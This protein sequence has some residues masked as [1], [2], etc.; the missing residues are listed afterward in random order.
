MF[1]SNLL[2]EVLQ[3]LSLNEF[4]TIV[5]RGCF[6]VLTKKDDT[7]L[8]K[9]LGN[10]DSFSEEHANNMKVMS[11]F[12]SAK[13]LTV[14]ARCNRNRLSDNVVYSRFGIPIMSLGSFETIIENDWLPSVLAVRGKHVVKIDIGLMKQN[15]KEMKMSLEELSRKIKISKK[16]LYEIENERVDPSKET[17][18]KLEDFFGVNLSKKYEIKVAESYHEVSPKSEFQNKV[19]SKFSEMKIECSC[20]SSSPFEIIGKKKEVLLTGLSEDERI[21]EANSKILSDISSFTNT[22]SVFI[23]KESQNKNVDGVPVILDSEIDEIDNYRD[24]SGLIRERKSA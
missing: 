3:I 5:F 19:Y 18:E 11:N 9:V 22:L 21:L 8:I 4:R 1:K 10:V 16:S 2:N 17:V 15:R 7:L 23:A 24:F 20:L 13:S 6:D 14:S 12:L